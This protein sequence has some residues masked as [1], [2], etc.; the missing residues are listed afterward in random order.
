MAII[1]TFDRSSHD[2]NRRNSLYYPCIIGNL[3]FRDEFARDC[4]LQR[5]VCLSP[6]SAF[7]GREPRRPRH[8]SLSLTAGER[9]LTRFTVLIEEQAK[10]C[11]MQ[12]PSMRVEN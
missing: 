4:F 11:L 3:A 2:Q 5:R 7:E 10:R 8:R 6:V 1:L 12:V 9:E